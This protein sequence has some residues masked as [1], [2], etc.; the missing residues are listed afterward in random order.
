ME[1]NK[2]ENQENTEEIK[3]EKKREL[4]EYKKIDERLKEIEQA[5]TTGNLDMDQSLELYEEAV[6][7]GVKASKTIENNVLVDM[8]EKNEEEDQN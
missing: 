7:L 3:E 8:V 4:Q 1:E 5:I 6:N 2:I